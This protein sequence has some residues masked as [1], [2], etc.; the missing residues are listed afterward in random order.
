MI[1]I[2]KDLYKPHVLPLFHSYVSLLATMAH[3][4]ETE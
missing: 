3:S 1:L 4:P 2:N